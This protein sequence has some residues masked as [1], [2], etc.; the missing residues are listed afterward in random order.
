MIL[1]AEFAFNLEDCV[2]ERSDARFEFGDTDEESNGD[3][4]ADDRGEETTNI[5]QAYPTRLA[6]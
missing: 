6:S 2:Y 1:N 5:L 3:E 4:G